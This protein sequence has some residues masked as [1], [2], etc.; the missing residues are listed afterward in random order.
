MTFKKQTLLSIQTNIKH[1]L[2]LFFLVLFHCRQN[3]KP[4]K[5]MKKIEKIVI[6]SV[7]ENI[8]WLIPITK[9]SIYDASLLRIDTISN[10]SEIKKFEKVYK[11]LNCS[12]MAQNTSSI[13]IIAKVLV[14]FGCNQNDTLLIDFLKKEIYQNNVLCNNYLPLYEF[15]KPYISKHDNIA[16]PVNKNETNL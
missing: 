11:L 12:G 7:P 1:I 10:L 3:D 14:E 5:N 6:L 4:L 16:E 2:M 13:N 15:F 9:S 8:D